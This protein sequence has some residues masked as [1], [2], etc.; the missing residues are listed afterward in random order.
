MGV[1]V[2]EEPAI[3]GEDS[4]YLR[5]ARGLASVRAFKQTSQVLQDD[6]RREVKGNQRRGFDGEIA[7][8]RFDKAGTFGSGIRIVLGLVAIAHADIVEEQFRH[9]RR[10]I[11]P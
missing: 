7:P 5:A 9:L 6:E 10:I 11:D 8:D 1:T 3:E 2:R 4:A